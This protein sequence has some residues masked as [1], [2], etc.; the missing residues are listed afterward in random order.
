MHAIAIASS[1]A[2]GV[3]E[4]NRTGGTVKR[5]HCGWAAQAGVSAAQL[6]ALGFTGPPT[7]LEGRFGLF[8]AFLHGQFDSA[9]VTDGLGQS[10]SVQDIFFKPYPANHFTHTII[11]A[12]RALREQG[13]HPADV[14]SVTVGVPLS[15]VRTVGEPIERKRRPSTPYEAQ[16]SGPYA[17]AVGAFGGGGLGAAIG[18]YRPELFESQDRRAFMD[19]VDV[20]ADPECTA[21]FP[22]QFPSIVRASTRDGRH[23]VA[24]AMHNRG[25]SAYPLTAAEL[26]VKFLDNSAGVLTGDAAT[27]MA[28]TIRD[29]A[30]STAPHDLMSDLSALSAAEND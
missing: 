3:I 14:A 25:G 15:V 2:S 16:F 6:A 7:V 24:K 29:L 23:W 12:T 11:D 22:H 4:S 9:A 27:S 18:D 19:C 5:L 1:M 10:W 28:A 17:A 13:L 30:G 26:Q 8:E 20:V 21:L